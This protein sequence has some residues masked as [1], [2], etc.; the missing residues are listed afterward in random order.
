VIFL[1]LYPLLSAG[2]A[3]A[4][5]LLG[6]GTCGIGCCLMILPYLGAVLL[7]PR[8]FFLRGIGIH[9]LRQWRPD[10][11]GPHAEDAS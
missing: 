1:R 7:L 6:C 9:I 8:D 5:L 4:A 3:L 10:L 2:A 11:A